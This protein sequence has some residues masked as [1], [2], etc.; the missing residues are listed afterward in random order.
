MYKLISINL[1]EYCHSDLTNTVKLSGTFLD[2]KV[3]LKYCQA[4]HVNGF[5]ASFCQLHRK[6]EQ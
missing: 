2:V 3:D 1:R 6:L 5:Q 4:Y